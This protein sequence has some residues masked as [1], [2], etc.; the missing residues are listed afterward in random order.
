M[1][2]ISPAGAVC[3]RDL[4][5]SIRLFVQ[6]NAEQDSPLRGTLEIWERYERF[7]R[8]LSRRCGWTASPCDRDLAVFD[9][10]IHAYLEVI[11]L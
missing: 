11:G 8:A 4:P 5:K 7:K 6:T 10:A 2:S 1:R 3:N 9:R